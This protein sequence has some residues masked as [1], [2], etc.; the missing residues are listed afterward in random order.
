LTPSIS[1]KLESF[2]S[3]QSRVRDIQIFFEASHDLV[4]KSQSRNTRTI[5]LL[6][7]IGLQA[8]VNV[9]SNDISNFSCEIF[10]LWNRAQP[11]NIL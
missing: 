1:D 10:V 2:L 8:R 7:V 11:P 9:E 3:S 5:E 6:R 4:E